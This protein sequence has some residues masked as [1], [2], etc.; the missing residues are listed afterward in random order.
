MP[1]M[2]ARQYQTLVKSIEQLKL[3]KDITREPISQSGKQ[4]VDFVM[5]NQT[6][7][8]LVSKHGPNN[9]KSLDTCP[10]PFV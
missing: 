5:Q 1:R 7:D 10:C 4:L 8:Y 6:E 9:F 3:E 2:T